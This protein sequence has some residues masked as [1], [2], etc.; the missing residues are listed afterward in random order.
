MPEDTLANTPGRSSVNTE[1]STEWGPSTSASHSTSTRRLCSHSNDWKFGQSTA[2]IV[3]P[4]PRVIYPRIGSPGT[5]LQ[6]FESCMR[7]SLV[8]PNLT[9]PSL[10]IPGDFKWGTDNALLAARES[11]CP[12]SSL[13]C[14]TTWS[15]ARRPNPTI[16]INSSTVS[17]PFTLAIAT[18]RSDCK[19]CSAEICCRWNCCSN[20]LRPSSSA[21]FCSATLN[22]CLIFVLAFDVRTNFSH[23]RW[24]TW[25]GDVKISAI[26]PLCNWHRRGTSLPFIFAPTQWS[27][28]SVWIA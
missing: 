22:Q 15:G 25:A 2:W 5:G 12:L 14:S 9:G 3:N 16:L 7:T 8:P 19:D 6:H 13:K 21:R 4:R 23:P 28:I 24:G 17:Q 10:K 26:S 11:D 18:N 27:P 1:T 20:N